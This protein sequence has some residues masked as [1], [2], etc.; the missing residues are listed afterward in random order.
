[1][2]DTRGVDHGTVSYLEKIELLDQNLLSA[3]TVWVN[4]DEVMILV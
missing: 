4:E 3:H 1:M 2:V